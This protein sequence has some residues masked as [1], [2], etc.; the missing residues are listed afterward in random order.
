[1]VEHRKAKLVSGY[2]AMK[3]ARR[4]AHDTDEIRPEFDE[5]K[6]S[7]QVKPGSHIGTTV[8]PT[9]HEIVCYECDYIFHITGRQKDTVCPKCRARLEILDHTIE[10]DWSGDLRTGGTIH[11]T[12]DAVLKS[13][14]I[15]GSNVILQGKI[16]GGRIRAFQWLELHDTAV[17]EEKD[18]EAKDLRIPAGADITLKRKAMFRRV[19][20]VGRLKAKVHASGLV[21]VRTGGLLEG[22]VHGPHLMVEDGGGLKVKAGILPLEAEE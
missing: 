5:A 14:E 10:G 6:G 22:E 1:M 4:A 13:G 7:G 2:A 20:V 21:S 17:F 3:A 19:D 9:K 16:D 11:V 15:K 8:L 12:T 18:F